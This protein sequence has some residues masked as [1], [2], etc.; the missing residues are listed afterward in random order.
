MR[1]RKKIDSLDLIFIL[2]N[3]FESIFQSLFSVG[4]KI[5]NF[6]FLYFDDYANI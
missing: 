6:L 2:K 1:I 3:T 4:K 5:L